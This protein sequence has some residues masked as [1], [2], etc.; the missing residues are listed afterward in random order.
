MKLNFLVSGMT[1]AACQANVT[2]CVSRLDGVSDVAVNLLSG[3]MQVHFDDQLITP[4]QISSAVSAIGYGCAPADADNTLRA[5]WDERKAR[6]ASAVASLRHRLIA[7]LALL[8]PLMYVAMGHMLGLPMPSF[9]S[10]DVNPLLSAL[11]QLALSLII[12]A[13]NR[14]FFTVGFRALFKGAPNMDT[15]VAIGSSAS[16]LY[17]LYSV[18]RMAQAQAAADMAAAAHWSHQLY[19]ESAAMILALVTLG[20]YLESRSKSKTSDALD[21]LVELAPKTA[22]VLRD[23]EEQ[24]IPAGLLQEGD[25]VIIRPGESI[26]ADGIITEG[27]G[28]CDQSAITGESIPVEKQVGDSV[29]CASI[30]RSGSFRFRASRV[31]DDTTLSQIIRLVDEA[32]SSKAPIA[33]LA[34]RV[35][36]IFVPMVIA[37]AVVTAIVWLLLGKGFEFALSCAISVLVISCPCALGLATPVAIM[38]GTGKAAENG[39]LIKSATAL[40]LLH[41]AN[42]IVLDKTG[43]VTSGHPSVTDIRLLCDMDEDTFLAAAAAAEE[44]SEHPL[45]GA[46]VAYAKERCA[47]IPHADSFSAVTGRGICAEV[48]GESWLAGNLAFMRENNIITD[49][50][51][52]LSAIETGRQLSLEG[53]TPLYFARGGQPCG[54]IAVAD[55]LRETS[56][57]AVERFGKLGL[58]IVLL[59]GDNAVTAEAV[60]ARLGIGRVLADV[61]PADKEACIRSLQEE[62][63]RVIMVGDGI[64]DAPALVRADVGIAIGAGTD[65]AIDSADVVLLK[66][67]LLDVVTAIELSRA[68]IRNIRGNL[69]WAFFYNILGIPVAA[70]AL[71]PLWGIRLS[72]MLGSAA[73]SL[74]SVCVVT[75]A[76]RLRFFRSSVGSD[77]SAVNISETEAQT[78][79]TACCEQETK[80]E[81]TMT[82]TMKIEGMMCPRCQAHVEKALSAVDGVA[83]ASADWEAGTAVVTL[84]ADVADDV[85]AAA[86]V[87]AGYTVL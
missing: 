78:N 83:A 10:A 41:S 79:E 67:S 21:K 14:R 54:I 46:V 65:I 40:E 87:E 52:S 31:G 30:N 75:N 2:R 34:D 49:D 50:E 35:S 39:I 51:L 56:I 17:G 72:P 45:A 66:D 26:P 80:G 25:I 77:E 6:A 47:A 71:W 29:I 53:K 33:R 42:T 3:T 9:L 68:V 16:L 38:V 1:C 55:T 37:V 8:V 58:D 24:L 27:Q 36:G 85:L 44:G 23:G 61:L 15:L 64:N 12:I 7:S 57:T 4:Q 62:G 74:S 5:R 82:K 86:V 73:M 63:R 59:T 11:V 69:F 84:T 70:G 28:F 32:G 13:I 20:K 76:L 43:T 48:G 18:V 60:R 22:A 81:I 19:F